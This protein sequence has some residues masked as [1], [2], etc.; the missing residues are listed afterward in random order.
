[1]RSDKAWNRN[2]HYHRLI[3]RSIP[4]NCERVLDVGCGQGLLTEE[5][6]NVCREIVAIDIDRKTLACA[7][8]RYRSQPRTTYVLGDVMTYPFPEESFDAIGAVATLHHLPLEAAL[9]RLRILLKPGGVLAVIG[10]YRHTFS[11]YPVDAL[12][13]VV[14]LTLRLRYS[15]SEVAAP[16]KAPNE[17]LDQIRA[18][19]ARVLPGAVVRRRLLFRYSLTWR[20][21]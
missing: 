18:V 16:V 13:M 14:S 15:Y 1:M 12:A 5:L 9:M 3:L 8:E 17:T 11:D 21:P 2:I 6:A 7:Q 19:C 4:H 10:L 20:K